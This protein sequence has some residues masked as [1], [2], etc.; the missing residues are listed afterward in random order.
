MG[1]STNQE[2]CKNTSGARIALFAAPL[3]V[4]L[5][6]TPGRSPN[7]LTQIPI[8]GDSCRFKERTYKGLGAAWGS[9]QL[10]ENRGCDH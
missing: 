3:C 10:R 9:N 2:I 7:W 6:C 8:N 1:V 4:R 5:E